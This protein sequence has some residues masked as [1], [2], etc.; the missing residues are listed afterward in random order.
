MY[1]FFDRL[2]RLF[3]LLGGVMLSALVIMTCLSIVGRVLNSFL[4]GELAQSLMPALAERLLDLGVG[5]VDG[6]IELVEVGMAFAIFAFLPLCQ[7]RGSHASVDILTSRFP[8]SA[9]GVLRMI[10]EL[11]FAIVMV[12]IAWHLMQGMLSKK[13]S[14]QTSFLLQYPVWWGYAAALTGAVATA[15]VSVYMVVARVIEVAT[16]RTVLPDDGAAS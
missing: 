10:T 1:R 12:L 7:L 11:V 14:G 13:N 15:L 5:A 8:A 3:A 4:Y 16:G 9:S 6:D 2:A